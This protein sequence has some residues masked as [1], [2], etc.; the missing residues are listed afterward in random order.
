MRRLD[1]TW[2]WAYGRMLLGGCS[3]ETEVQRIRPTHNRARTGEVLGVTPSLGIS[4]SRGLFRALQ[5]LVHRWYCAIILFCRWSH[6]DCDDVSLG[7]LTGDVLIFG[8]CGSAAQQNVP[9]LQKRFGS[10]GLQRLID[11]MHQTWTPSGAVGSSGEIG[12][13]IFVFTWMNAGAM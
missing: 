3:R 9:R 7:D 8:R 10:A 2:E 13:A 12:Q 1:G 11:S 6:T 4:A 5:R